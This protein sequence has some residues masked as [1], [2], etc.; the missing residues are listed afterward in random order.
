MVEIHSHAPAEHTIRGNRADLE[1]H[2]VH[3]SDDGALGVIGLL[4]NGADG[5]HPV[6]DL[7]EPSTPG[8][9]S[10]IVEPIALSRLIPKE[11]MRFMYSGSLTT[12]PY[13]EGVSWVV[14]DFVGHVGR[15][16]LDVFAETF[17]PTNRPV[18][19]LGERVVEL[20]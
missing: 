11:A 2:L 3:R 19:P 16:A 6:D 5:H 7:V 1:T 12:P 15:Q 20:V 9:V 18:Q 13:T 4:F 8:S 10:E 14:Y 17:G